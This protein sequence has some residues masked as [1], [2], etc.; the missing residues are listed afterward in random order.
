MHVDETTQRER[1]DMCVIAI[2]DSSIHLFGLVLI[3]CA[4]GLPCNVLVSKP[5]L[6]VSNSSRFRN[7]LVTVVTHE[8]L[9]GRR[10][11]L[12]SYARLR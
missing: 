12:T 6:V 1:S 7:F 2:E 9:F 11:E 5:I 8:R 10:M 3:T 4:S